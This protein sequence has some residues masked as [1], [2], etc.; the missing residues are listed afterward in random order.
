MISPMKRWLFLTP[1]FMVFAL[2][3]VLFCIGMC[4]PTKLQRA[5][6]RGELVRIHI[7]AQDDTEGQQA[8]KLHVRDAVIAAFTPYL[9]EAKNSREAARIVR[10][11]LT[12]AQETAQKATRE[13]GATYPVFA[14]FGVYDFPTRV[15]GNEIVPAGEYPALRI[16]LG[17]GKGRNWWC[18]MYPPLCFCGEDIE[19]VHFESTLAK[20]W[21]TLKNGRKAKN[22]A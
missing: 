21:K 8:I 7:L 14:A 13:M 2:T 18:V 5:I 6:E 3:M 10:Q 20:W 11:N 9:E 19:E 4:Y 16:L 22:H 17:E 12:L 15:Y 1:L